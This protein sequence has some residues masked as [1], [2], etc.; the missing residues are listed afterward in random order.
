M[1]GYIY[2]T[3]NLI[4]G[5][6][7]IGKH[8]A[9]TFEPEKYKGS[10]TILLRAFSK[11]GKENFKCEL[12]EWCETEDDLNIREKYW[13]NYFNCQFNDNYYNLAS[14]GEGGIGRD[15]DNP[16]SYW[17][18]PVKREHAK[19]ETKKSLK[20]YYD[21][22]PNAHA[23]K[24]NPMYGKKASDET[25]QKLSTA[26][27]NSLGVQ[28]S[29]RFKGHHHTTESKEKISAWS[30]T[31][32]WINNGEV[33]KYI[34]DIND[35]PDGFVLGRLK[36]KDTIERENNKKYFN[37]FN[38]KTGSKKKV[39]CI[40]LNKIFE[41]AAAAGKE[42]HVCTSTI[43]ECCHGKRNKAGGYHWKFIEGDN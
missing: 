23:G 33:S 27:K 10:G 26:F 9:I 22:H 25:R 8:K 6:M 11:Y 20:K 4:N 32:I 41:S 5:K 1:I 13:I 16:N 37:Q 42:L 39:L 21:N 3:T 38:N 17:S 30:K 43:S 29:P 15:I 24:N 19:K 14:G 12:I 36:S 2:K 18:D 40:E 28:N 34:Y 7:Y 35:I 31:K